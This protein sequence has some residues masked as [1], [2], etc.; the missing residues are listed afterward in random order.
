MR[1]KRRAIVAADR[2]RQ[3]MLTESPFKTG[4]N[5]LDGG[6]DNAGFDQKTA[7]TVCYRQGIDPPLV[8]GAKPALEVRTPLIIGARHRRAG[9]PLVERATAPL[10][11]RDQACALENAPDRRGGRPGDLGRI[12]IKHRQQLAR[13]QIRKSPPR[14]DHLLCNRTVRGLPTLQGRMRAVLKPGRIA[15]LFPL[16][17]F[18]K[19]VAANPVAPAHLRYAPVP[20]LVLQKHPNTLFHPTGLSKWHRRVLPPTHSETCRGSSRSKMSGIYP[21][22]TWTSCWDA[23]AP[24]R[25]ISWSAGLAGSRI[26][27][28]SKRRTS[29]VRT[30]WPSAGSNIHWRRVAL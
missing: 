28:T 19:R 24:A 8:A 30:S 5:A 23:C 2:K 9:P 18:V 7:V 16:A 13:P 11:R 10:H 21:V 6:G 14:R 25:S 22:R 12:P 26:Y 27:P 3:A 4:A 15:A 29:I 1:A 17:P 20:A